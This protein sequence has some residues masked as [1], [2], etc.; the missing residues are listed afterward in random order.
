MFGSLDESRR[1]HVIALLR[2]LGDRFPQIVLITH[3]EGVREGA[4]RVLRVTF[5]P[6]AGAAVVTEEEGAPL[7][8]VAA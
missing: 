2:H 3:V 7:N 8:D 1:D 6:T 5:D 4:D